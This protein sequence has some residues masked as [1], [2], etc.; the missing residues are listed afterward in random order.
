[1]L[2]CNF[3]QTPGHIAITRNDGVTHDLMLAGD[4]LGNQFPLNFMTNEVNASVGEVEG[5][6]K[7]TPGSSPANARPSTTCH[8][9]SSRLLEPLRLFCAAFLMLAVGI[10]LA[11]CNE[12][13]G[14]YVPVSAIARGGFVT[15]QRALGEARGG[16]VRLWGYVDQG[17]L[18]GDADA[19][20]TLGQ[21]WSGEGPDP[22]H[23]RFDLKAHADDPLGHSFVV[24]VPNDAGRDDLLERLAADAR[25]QRATKVFVTGRLFTFDAPMQILGRTG[26]W[27]QLRSSQDIRLDRPDGN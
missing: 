16:E 18:Y 6:S 15:D 26:L 19:K 27:L 1:M 8:D 3:E 14:E 22:D 25:A 20:R 12:Q 2:P 10:G 17:N 4:P 9:A 7:T 24:L 21:W 11:G 23:W 13:I 5:G